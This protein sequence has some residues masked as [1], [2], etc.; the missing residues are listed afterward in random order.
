MI[1]N[2]FSVFLS[3]AFLQFYL[4]PILAKEVTKTDFGIFLSI[5]GF[6]NFIS[7][8]VGGSLGTVR[9]LKRSN[10]DHIVSSDFRRLF[11]QSLIIS[12]VSILIILSVLDFHNNFQEIISILAFN[13]I[14]TSK[15]FLL[16]Y[17]RLVFNY[18]AIFYNSLL[19]I[20]IYFSLQHTGLIKTKE[21]FVFLIIGE[22]IGIAILLN[23]AM[24]KK[25]IF[26]KSEKSGNYTLTRN[27]YYYLM[28]TNTLNNLSSYMDKFI[29]LPFVG[30][31]AVSNYYVASFAAKVFFAGI[32]PITSVILTYLSVKSKTN[33]K[34]FVLKYIYFSLTIIIVLLP[35]LNLLSKELILLLYPNYYKHISSS[36][37]IIN[38][39][40]VIAIST[41]ILQ[42][43]LMKNLDIHF[44]SKTQIILGV[45]SCLS[46][47]IGTFYYGTLGFYWSIIISNII[48]LISF[49][50]YL[51]RFSD[52]ENDGAFR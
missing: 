12:T 24:M 46:C 21:I 19:V 18:K 44:Y 9:L 26:Y 45:F 17:S 22:L 10:Y 39:G 5:I 4:Y 15:S 50:Y 7:V 38:L 40:V 51:I 1:L 31:I 41:S 35:L 29:L 49:I 43:L 48:K 2:V 3:L 13:L 36:L 8:V 47:L 28:V 32:S 34:K 42:P 14:I 27:N 6:I 52:R 11:V 25:E 20:C 37:L 16:I 30:A 23:S 33:E